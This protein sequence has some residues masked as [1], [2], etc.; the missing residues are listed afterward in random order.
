M[1][2][3]NPEFPD[4]DN[5]AFSPCHSQ[6]FSPIRFDLFSDGLSRTALLSERLVGT[7]F[8][9][10]FHDPRDFT[11]YH[12]VMPTSDDLINHCRGLE[13]DSYTKRFATGGKYWLFG[14]HHHTSYTDGQSPNS[15]GLDR[16]VL[17]M[18]PPIGMSTARSSHPGG[19]LRGNGR[20]DR[21]IRD[22]FD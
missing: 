19:V 18:M 12:G 22:R 13:N 4:S 20:R 10:G 2:Y 7:N 16:I 6:S 17:A 14:G 3:P 11:D 8:E 21:S 5:G 15:A 1:F 9:N